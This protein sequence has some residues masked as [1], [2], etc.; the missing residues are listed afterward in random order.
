MVMKA[1]EYGTMGDSR[2]HSGPVSATR[3]CLSEC[4]RVMAPG[5]SRMMSVRGGE[6]GAGDETPHGTVRAP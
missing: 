4:Q 3:T 5:R 1:G 6:M 2:E